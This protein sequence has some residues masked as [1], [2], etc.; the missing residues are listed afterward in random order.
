[1]KVSI[2]IFLNE[3]QAVRDGGFDHLNYESLCLI[4]DQLLRAAAQVGRARHRAHTHK[5]SIGN[6]Q[7]EMGRGTAQ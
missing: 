4:E 3:C 5:S 7:A 6:R 2:A 1:M